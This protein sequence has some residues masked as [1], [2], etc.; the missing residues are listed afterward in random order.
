MQWPV[1]YLCALSPPAA[2][3]AGDAACS[4]LSPISVPSPLQQ[5]WW[6]EM[7]H[8]VACPLSLCPLPSSSPGGRRCCMQWP[9]PYLCALSPPAAVVAGDAACSGLSPISV[10][11]PLQQP[12]WQEMLHAVA[13]LCS[14]AL[15][16]MEETAVYSSLTRSGSKTIILI[17]QPTDPISQSTDPTPHHTGPTP[18]PTG[19]CIHYTTIYY[20]LYTTIYNPSIL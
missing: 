18:Q 10:P 8:A 1:P 9:V 2:L 12:W 20:T 3:V 17:A 13:G 5:S 6:Q 11:S 15:P 7:L 19:N 16:D 14:V 4:G